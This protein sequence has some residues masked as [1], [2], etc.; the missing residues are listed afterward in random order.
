MLWLEKDS[1]EIKHGCH[2]LT[3]YCCN[4]LYKCRYAIVTSDVTTPPTP[5]FVG[6]HGLWAGPSEREKTFVFV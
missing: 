4:V 3:M 1:D 2:L 5:A 6:T